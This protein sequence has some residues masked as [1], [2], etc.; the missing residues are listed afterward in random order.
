TTRS[1]EIIGLEPDLAAYLASAM[2]VKLRLERL[3]FS[4]LLGALETGK[5]DM[6]LSAMTITPERNLRVAF[7]GPY[8][9]SGKCVLTKAS[10][11]ASAE[12]AAEINSANLTVTALQ[13]S[14]SQA[15][16]EKLIPAARLTTAPDY[17]TAVSRVLS[18]EA[19]VMI[20]DYPICLVAHA[21]NPDSD[22]VSVI[23]RLTHEPIGIAL[24][25][26]D[27]LLLNFVDNLLQGLEF[28][29]RLAQL[30]DRWFEDASW[31]EQLP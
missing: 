15:F 30:Q 3:Q 18:G 28:T 21:R 23:T 6:V 20:A 7:A 29:G 1:G 12:S 22:L 31:L 19:D 24:P 16:V 8:F 5:V 25:A 10:S 4:E 9:V 14:T 11:L 17:D 26:G 13:G 2:G 27:P